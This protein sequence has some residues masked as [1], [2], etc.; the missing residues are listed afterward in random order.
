MASICRVNRRIIPSLR[1][2]EDESWKSP[3]QKFEHFGTKSQAPEAHLRVAHGGIIWRHHKDLRQSP[4]HP[5]P[6]L[7]GRLATAAKRGVVEKAWEN[8]GKIWNIPDEWRFIAGKIISLSLY[9]SISIYIY[10]CVC[11]YVCM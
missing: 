4:G 8:H 5:L 10:I 6:Q 11:V 1:T 7:V 9:I 3:S 2:Y